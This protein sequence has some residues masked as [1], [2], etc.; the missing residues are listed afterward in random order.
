MRNGAPGLG[1]GLGAPCAFLCLP[2]LTLLAC[3]SGVFDRCMPVIYNLYLLWYR[4]TCGNC[5]QMATNAECV[6]CQ[7]IPQ[8][9]IELENTARETRDPI[10]ACITEHPGFRE[11]CLNHWVLEIAWLTYR[12]QY[13]E[14]YDGPLH[15]R[16]RHIAY[17]QLA[18]LIWKYLGRHVR[19]ILPACG[20][21]QIR[22]HFQPP[23]DEQFIGFR[24]PNLE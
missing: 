18:R 23:A 4:C 13:N 9:S 5:Q 24:L 6:C 8:V 14:P 12:S 19:V 2:L 3:I 1:A 11:V 10:A 15:M 21:T 17:R 22:D 16:Y 7:E 20:V